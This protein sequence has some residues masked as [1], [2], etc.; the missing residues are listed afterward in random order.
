MNE[1]LG[2]VLAVATAHPRET[3]IAVGLLVIVGWR[4][5]PRRTRRRLRKRTWLRTKQVSRWAWRRVTSSQSSRRTAPGRTSPY[6]QSAAPGGPAV[7]YRHFD[8]NDRLLYV[9]ITA[10][11][12]NGRRWEEHEADKPWFHQVARSEVTPPYPTRAAALYAEAVAIRDE[13]PIHNI[14]RPDPT[15]IEVSP[16]K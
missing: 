11:A 7:L 4:K 3:A 13:N 14:C 15:R 12:R 5:M 6:S 1:W 16:W 2:T 9:G 8:A 10:E